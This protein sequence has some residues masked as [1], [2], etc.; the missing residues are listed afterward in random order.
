MNDI[1]SFSLSGVKST[2]ER[3]NKSK[4]SWQQCVFVPIYPIPSLQR[5]LETLLMDVYKKDFQ[6]GNHK[7]NKVITV[8]THIETTSVVRPTN[9]T[10]FERSK[11]VLPQ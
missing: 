10:I 4:F 9:K 2:T 11:K 7:S 6:K 5:Y 8:E 1:L 3:L